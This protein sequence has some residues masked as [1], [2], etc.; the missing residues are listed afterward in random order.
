MASGW[1]SC[2]TRLAFLACLLQPFSI[3]ELRAQ[4]RRAK[5]HAMKKDCTPQTAGS[6]PT[7]PGVVRRFH[8]RRPVGGDQW[9]GCRQRRND[10]AI[11][12]AHIF[13][14]PVIAVKIE[15]DVL[16][17]KVSSPARCRRALSL[18][19][20]F[21]HRKA[22]SRSPACCWASCRMAVLIR[23]SVRNGSASSSHTQFEIVP[24]PP[25]LVSSSSHCARR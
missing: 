6:R 9:L 24:V 3:I 15:M 12:S 4:R 13:P 17:K 10:C 22:A 19:Q 16:I 23:V 18:R 21:R 8:M 11:C 7:S 5:R 20:V 14:E 25:H 1:A 2:W